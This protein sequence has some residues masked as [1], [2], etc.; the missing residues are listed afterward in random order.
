MRFL[1]P[2]GRGRTLA[3]GFC[4]ELLP[5]RLP[6]GGFAGSLL[7]TSHVPANFSS[8]YLSARSHPRDHHIR[9]RQP[10]E[11]HPPK[12]PISFF[13]F[14]GRKIKIRLGCKESPETLQTIQTMQIR[15]FD[16][17]PKSR[18]LQPAWH[19]GYRLATFKKKKA[20]PTSPKLDD[21]MSVGVRA[22]IVFK[23]QT[24]PPKISADD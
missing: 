8:L 7:G 4:R 11:K 14:H 12:M 3:S 21:K 24:Y 17:N 10:L 16:A 2:A 19:S 20:F 22:L 15:T 5:G 18:L 6:P 1:D 23:R 13:V 9:A